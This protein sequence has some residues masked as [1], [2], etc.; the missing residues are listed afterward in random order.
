MLTLGIQCQGEEG[1][2]RASN[3][4]FAAPVTAKIESNPALKRDVLPEAFLR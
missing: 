1:F 2:C 4:I 3:I